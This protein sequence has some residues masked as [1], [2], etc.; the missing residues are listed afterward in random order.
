M[1]KIK[2]TDY[3]PDKNSA[4]LIATSISILES[5]RQQGYQLTLRQLYYQLVSR[6]ILPNTV[7]SYNRLG[8]IVSRAREGGLIDWR[9]I[10]DRSRRV[11]SNPHW[12]DAKDF[13]QSV[14]PQFSLDWWE[15]Q[16][17]RPIVFV[18][19]EALEEIV[20]MACEKYDVPY[21][22]NKGYLSASAIWH[23][24]HDLMLKADNDCS[25]FVV[26]HLGDHDPSGIDMSRDI[27]ARLKLFATSYESGTV[28]PDIEVVRLALNMDQILQYQPPPNPAKET[29]SRFAE[30]QKIHG[31]ESWE[32]DALEPS[33][34]DQL[35]SDA[36]ESVISD[37]TAYEDRQLEQ[38][39]TRQKLLKIRIK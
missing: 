1:P 14:A 19:K 17:R 38:E 22:A 30:Y 24:A 25:D 6:D 29:D 8:G 21:F 31:D 34:I 20:G 3:R 5:Y 15:G 7:K 11:R 23:V 32:L 26:F 37:R 2:Y 33:V 35:I 10:V 39:Q 13:M 27:E 16:D 12:Q 18:E 4:A 9:Y 36:I 28:T